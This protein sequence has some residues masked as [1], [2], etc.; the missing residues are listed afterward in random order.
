MHQIAY[1]T[2]LQQQKY[3]FTV[4]GLLFV[5]ALFSQYLQG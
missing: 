4:N 5:S 3:K 2:N 1:T